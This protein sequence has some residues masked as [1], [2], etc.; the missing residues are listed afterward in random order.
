MIQEEKIAWFAGLFEG[1]GTFCITNGF[2]SKISITSTDKDVLLKVQEY[3]QGNLIESKKQKNHHKIPYIW[4]LCG[5]KG[6][7]LILSIQKFL[8]KRRLERSN[9]YL[10]LLKSRVVKKQQQKQIRQSKIDKILELHKRG[11]IHKDIA[12]EVGYERSHVTKLI[13]LNT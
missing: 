1:E 8:S 9:E 5:E 4:S 12:Y 13:R 2:A 10:Y 7:H 6:I 3:F 11:L